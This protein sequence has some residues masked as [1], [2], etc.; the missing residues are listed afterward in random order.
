MLTV[1]CVVT[2]L[3]PV[4]ISGAVEI[5][6]VEMPEGEQSWLVKFDSNN[7]GGMRWVGGM[8]IFGVTSLE[9]VGS[10]LYAYGAGLPGLGLYRINPANGAST[11]IGGGGVEPGIDI[12]DFSFNARDGQL[13]ALGDVPFPYTGP[14][15]LYT[16]NT[17]TGYATKLGNVTGMPNWEIPVGLA[18]DLD[19]T[20]YIGD[21]QSQRMY[22]LLF[23][24]LDATPLP[25]KIG[26]EY[27]EDGGMTIDWAGDGRWHFGAWGDYPQVRSEYRLVD[28]STGA[29]TLVGPFPASPVITDLAIVPEPAALALLAVAAVPL[30]R[31]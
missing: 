30:R 13:Y 14:P 22:K 8:K 10:S 11:F 27:W 18:A 16:I 26:V 23:G 1:I 9:W 3:A 29:T 17:A 31:R 25:E 12:Q 21:L 19:G 4:A 5:Y 28:K 2:I 15:R 6:G 20:M 7:V 24:S